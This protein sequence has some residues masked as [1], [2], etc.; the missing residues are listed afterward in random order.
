MLLL[1]QICSLHHATPASLLYRVRLGALTEGPREL[2]R[3]DA[4]DHIIASSEQKLDPTATTY[5][6]SRAGE[7]LHVMIGP[8]CCLACLAADGR[9]PR[10]ITRIDSNP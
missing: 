8:D 6:E 3:P 9:I 10:R 4:S 1:L 2:A 7:H 5:E